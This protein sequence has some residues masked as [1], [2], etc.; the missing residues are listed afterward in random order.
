MASFQL[1]LST[2][3][4]MPSGSTGSFRAQVR[5]WSSD[6]GAAKGA[7]RLSDGGDAGKAGDRAQ[8]PSPVVPPLRI[9]P[10]T[11]NVSE[12]VPNSYQRRNTFAGISRPP[13]YRANILT[14]GNDV[15]PDGHTDEYAD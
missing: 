10:A 6:H 7:S 13:G 8:T 5:S 15:V 1:L 11:P 4:A 2:L 14:S 9:D 12:T 3:V